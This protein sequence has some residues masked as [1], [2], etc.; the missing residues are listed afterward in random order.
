MIVDGFRFHFFANEGPRPHI[1][2]EKGGG[3]AKIWLDDMSL[4]YWDRLTNADRRRI[5]KI[6]KQHRQRLLEAWNE[7]FTP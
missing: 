1:H 5:L 7:F 4:A 3:A 2:V 6:A